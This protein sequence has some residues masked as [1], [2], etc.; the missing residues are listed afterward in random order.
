VENRMIYSDEELECLLDDIESDL[1][2]RKEPW[3]GDAPEKGRQ[4]VCAFA[5]GADGHN[6]LFSAHDSRGPFRPG[7]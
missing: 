7:D 4:A 2:E 1:A 6:P 5:D 3:K